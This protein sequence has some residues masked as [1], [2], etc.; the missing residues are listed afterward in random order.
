MK[1]RLLG[2]VC[3][4]FSSLLKISKEPQ[5]HRRLFSVL[6]ATSLMSAG[7]AQ[8][9]LIVNTGA[10]SATS[11]GGSVSSVQW[12]AGQFTLANSYTVNSVEGWFGEVTEGTL[13]AAIYTDSGSGVPISE[14]FSQ[15]FVLDN[16]SPGNNTWD[17]AFGLSWAFAPGTY[18]LAFEVRSGDT[19]LGFMPNGTDGAPNPLADYAVWLGSPQFQWFSQDSSVAYGM[20]IDAV[21]IPAAVWLFGSGLLG[22]IGIARRKKAA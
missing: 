19:G 2:A 4:L 6:A 13:T 21:P 16:P 10:G 12:L 1:S 7:N 8:A 5:L 9:I 20:R 11:G 3:G 14:L 18:W 15:Q 22:L 17:G